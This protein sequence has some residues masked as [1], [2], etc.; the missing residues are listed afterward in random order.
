MIMFPDTK[1]S[2]MVGGMVGQFFDMVSKME[3]IPSK[4]RAILIYS[5][6]FTSLN[7]VFTSVMN[8][9]EQNIIT[10]AIKT[11]LWDGQKVVLTERWA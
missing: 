4:V 1:Q 8:N 2:L 6:L 11:N 3:G 7:N 9:P 10:F 5:L